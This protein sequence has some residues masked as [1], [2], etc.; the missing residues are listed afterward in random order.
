MQEG[1]HAFFHCA[2]HNLG[3]STVNDIDL[4][5]FKEL[6]GDIIRVHILYTNCFEG[7]RMLT[8]QGSEVF[9]GG[10]VFSRL[11]ANGLEAGKICEG[12]GLAS[13]KKIYNIKNK[14][15]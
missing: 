15:N 1:S 11:K 9:F 10:C 13:Q 14:N 7:P 5:F 2:V 12:T 6:F 8:L 3:N 4:P